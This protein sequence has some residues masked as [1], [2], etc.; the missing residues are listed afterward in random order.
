MP[1]Q[2]FEKHCSED[3]KMIRNEHL[4]ERI[5]APKKERTGRN[6]KAAVKGVQI[7][8]FGVQLGE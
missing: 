5:G 7:K 4:V 6:L 2:L 8:C 1:W 3:T